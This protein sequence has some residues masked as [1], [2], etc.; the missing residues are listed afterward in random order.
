VT[1]A[2]Q[3]ESVRRRI[4]AASER[5]GR[6]PSEVLLV[7]ACKGASNEA[8]GEALAAGLHDFGENFIQEARERIDTLGDKAAGASWHF[9]GHLQ[10]NKVRDAID[11]FAI[12]QSVDSL[13]LAEQIS[14]RATNS[15]RILLEVNVAGET[16]KF[17][18]EPAEVGPAVDAVARLPNIDL[19]GLMTIAPT[20]DDPE[21]VRPYFRSLRELATA[22]GL[23]QL[24]MGMTD[25]F[26]VAVEEGATIVRVGRAIFGE[27]R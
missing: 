24:S 1:I 27:R 11:L 10:T 21:D 4:A 7:G 20:A 22:N 18:L 26:E 12:I 3:I 15:S 9:I 14:R 13:R 23:T 25:D 19:M 16:S 6:D 8:V 2:E 17:G 5:A